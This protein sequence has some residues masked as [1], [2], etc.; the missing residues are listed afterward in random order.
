MAPKKRK[1]RRPRN[2]KR[3]KKTTRRRIID[4]GETKLQKQ[5]RS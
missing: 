1:T 5:F 2:R 3:M 4:A